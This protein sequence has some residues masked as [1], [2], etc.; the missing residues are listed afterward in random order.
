M[1][2]VIA[3]IAVLAA[4]LLP[5]VQMAIESGR[6]AACSNN[7][8]NLA[9]AIQ[10][11]DSAKGQLPASR[12]FWNNP[13]YKLNKFNNYPTSLTATSATAATLT[14]VHELMPYIELQNVRD[15]IEGPNGL[16][17]GTA[18]WAVFGGSGKIGVVL[19]PSDD[20]N[21]NDQTNSPTKGLDYSQLSYGIN[22]GVPDNLNFTTSTAA[23]G[24][25]W[26]ANGVIE[27]KMRGSNE[28]GTLKVFKTTLG[29]VVNGDGSTNTMILADNGDLEEWNY[30]PS[31]YYVGIAW[32]E[33]DLLNAV[34]PS[35][36]PPTPTQII[37]GYVQ[38]NSKSADLASVSN[39]L[40]YA[41]PKSNHPAGFMAAFCDGR[42]KF[43]AENVA[44]GVYCKL[45]TSNGKKYAAAGMQPNAP[46]YAAIRNALTTPPL[47]AKDY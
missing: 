39:P 16:R 14:W 46:A 2:V 11:F 19:C 32:N 34:S 10:Q 17:A 31:E 45:L 15:Q 24:L 4:L 8:K 6:R 21:D 30:A 35:N 25:D 44:Y 28:L 3:I 29:D 27:N 26:P 12:T 7:L 9:L 33:T 41:R 40:A 13:D 47:N 1:L 20:K 37:N 18:I 38:G 22:V 36:P 5:A 42:T 43:I 23:Y